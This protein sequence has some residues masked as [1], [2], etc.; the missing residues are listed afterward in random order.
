MTAVMMTTTTTTTMMK[1]TTSRS[2]ARQSQIANR[3]R[4]CPSP[5]RAR[6]KVEM[7]WCTRAR[8][9]PTPNHPL[10]KDVKLKYDGKPVDLPPET[11]EVAMFYAV[12]I[13]TQH[14]QNPIFNRNFFDDFTADLKKF[15]AKRRHPDQVVRQARLPRHVQ[16]LESLKDAEN[17][18]K[19]AL[20]PS[21]RK[22]EIE[23]PKSRRTPGRSAS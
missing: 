22:R 14:A 4:P 15:P 9:S 12:K 16:L 19:K 3:Q 6:E 18:R 8:A 7:C 11:E 1:T 13:E 17:E 2:A 21:A 20:A 10:P 5:A 23:A